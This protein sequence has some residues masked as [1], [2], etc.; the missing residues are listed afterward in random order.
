MT[1]EDWLFEKSQRASALRELV[2]LPSFFFYLLLLL[3]LLA[4]LVVAFQSMEKP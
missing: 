4:T 2:D 1:G 3:N